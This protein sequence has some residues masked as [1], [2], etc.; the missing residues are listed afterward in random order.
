MRLVGV[1]EREREFVARQASDRK[2]LCVQLVEKDSVVYAIGC[3]RCDV[4]R[5]SAVRTAAVREVD[6]GTAANV[7]NIV[8]VAKV[9]VA[10]LMLP[11]VASPVMDRHWGCLVG[12]ESFRTAIFSCCVH[13]RGS[14]T[15]KTGPVKYLYKN[16]AEDDICGCN[17][18]WRAML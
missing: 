12:V 4:K 6:V 8:G 18:Q 5:M 15:L 7:R 1:A 11:T 3:V 10:K 14:C 16:V 2:A 13:K 9:M 17:R